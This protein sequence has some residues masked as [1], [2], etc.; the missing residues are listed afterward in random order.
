MRQPFKAPLCFDMS[1]ALPQVL[2]PFALA[3]YITVARG[4]KSPGEAAQ[5][6]LLN[7]CFK[8]VVVSVGWRSPVYWPLIESASPRLQATGCFV[9]LPPVAAGGNAV[10]ALPDA[11]AAA[12]SPPWDHLRLPTTDDALLGRPACAA[13]TK[14]DSEWRRRLWLANIDDDEFAFMRDGSC[15][16]DFLPQFTPQGNVF[17]QASAC[18]EGVRSEV[19]LRRTQ[20]P[21]LPWY[22]GSSTAATA[23]PCTRATPSSPRRTHSAGRSCT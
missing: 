17:M 23:T 9:Q 4:R 3:G 18:G 21:S 15:I 6:R 22:S 12:F 2:S 19:K 20:T 8:A 1:S 5:N 16:A 11:A 14:A 13:A 7:E 10:G